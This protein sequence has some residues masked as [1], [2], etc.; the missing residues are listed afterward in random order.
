MFRF[1]LVNTTQLEGH[2]VYVDPSC[3]A[4]YVAQSEESSEPC[5]QDT[6]EAIMSDLYKDGE[7]HGT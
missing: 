6:R 5:A 3:Y 1:E 7:V 4:Q 2:Q